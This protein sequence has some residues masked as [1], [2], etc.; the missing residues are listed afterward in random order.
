MPKCTFCGNEIEKGQ[1]KMFV[2]TSGKIA[3][4]CSNKCE[5]N[6]LKLKRKPLET[7]WTE[8]YRKEHKKGEKEVKAQ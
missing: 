5:K 4:F 1:V 3:N 2:Y 8:Y 6:L 7:R